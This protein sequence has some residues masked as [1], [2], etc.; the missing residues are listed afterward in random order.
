V[1]LIL[2]GPH[3][4]LVTPGSSTTTRARGHPQLREPRGDGR[5]RGI[6]ASDIPIRSHSPP[7]RHGPEQPVPNAE[8]WI[9]GEE[10]AFW[11]GPSAGPGISWIANVD[12]L[13]R[14]VT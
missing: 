11:T 7:L 5:A 4:L 6:K 1:W 13:A 12:A 2:G 14:L 9:Q 10:V 3:P 8:F